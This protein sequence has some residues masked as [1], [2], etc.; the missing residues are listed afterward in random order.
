MDRL[1]SW[2]GQTATSSATIHKPYE[3]KVNYQSKRHMQYSMID[4]FVVTYEVLLIQ[5]ASAIMTNEAKLASEDQQNFFL[6]MHL[7]KRSVK[8]EG[9]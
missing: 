5:S 1:N 4:S 7:R 9:T 3:C 8:T 2:R 6:S